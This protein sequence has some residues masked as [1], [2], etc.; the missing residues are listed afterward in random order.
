M[1]PLFRTKSVTSTTAV[2]SL[3]LLNSHP[4]PTRPTPPPLQ[5][6]RRLYIA[7]AVIELSEADD[8]LLGELA[9]ENERR[10]VLEQEIEQVSAVIQHQASGTL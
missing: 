8:A 4:H 9:V 1:C 7:C 3:P 10:E 2:R 5:P 6:T